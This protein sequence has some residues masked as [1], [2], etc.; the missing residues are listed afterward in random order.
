MGAVGL[1]SRKWSL[2]LVTPWMVTCCSTSAVREA[3]DTAPMCIIVPA[4][5]IHAVMRTFGLNCSSRFPAPSAGRCRGALRLPPPSSTSAKRSCESQAP[6]VT[7]STSSCLASPTASFRLRHRVPPAPPA[8]HVAP[9]RR[10]RPVN[11]IPE[12]RKSPV[13]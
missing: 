8:F 13:M 5:S 11:S 1:P 9:G 7:S 3:L 10:P 4:S 6:R 12:A 2:V